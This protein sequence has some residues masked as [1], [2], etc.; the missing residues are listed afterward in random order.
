ML[1]KRQINIIPLF[2]LAGLLILT[3]CFEFVDDKDNFHPYDEE[4]YSPEYYP[5][6]TY[7]KAKT[8]TI[9]GLS[10]FEEKY[11]YVG[12][13]QN[14]EQVSLDFTFD[15]DDTTRPEVYGSSY[16]YEGVIEFELYHSYYENWNGG[17][18][19]YVGFRVDFYDYGT[20][21]TTR[22]YF[23][24]RSPI[25]FTSKDQKID[26]SEFKVYVFR[27]TAGSIAYLKSFDISASGITLD[28]LLLT[29]NC[30]NY[31]QMLAKEKLKELYK[32]EEKTL[33]FNGG[34][35]LYSDTVIYGEADII[36]Q[37]KKD[38]AYIT[39]IITLTDIPL[40]FPDNA[41]IG[42]YDSE[43]KITI[44]DSSG[45]GRKI[46]SD[47]I[48]WDSGNFSN[49]RW[50]IPINYYYLSSD[51]SFSDCNFY[52]T[53]YLGRKDFGG[54][55]YYTVPIQTNKTI[56]NKNAYVGDLGKVSLKSVVVSGHVYAV[57][58]N[59]L[60]SAISVEIKTPL[61]LTTVDAYFFTYPPSIPESWREPPFWSVRLPVFSSPTQLSFSV[62][63]M[64][65]ANSYELVYTRDISS[66]VVFVENENVSNVNFYVS[67]K[68]VVP[69]NAY[70]LIADTW[71]HTSIEDSAK[72]DWYSLDVIKGKDYYFWLND[73]YNGDGSKTATVNTVVFNSGGYNKSDGEK[74]LY[75]SKD[76]NDPLVYTAGSSGTVYIKVTAPSEDYTGTY[77]IVYS[78]NDS[79]PAGGNA[80]YTVSFNNNGG[81]GEASS[82]SELS[83][84]EITLPL[85][86]GFSRDGYVFGGW[87]TLANGAG[88]NYVPGAS[89]KIVGNVTL[90]AKW[91]PVYTVTFDKNSNDASGTVPSM[92]ATNDTNYIITL[93]DAYELSN[94]TYLF[95]SWNTK[96][97]GTGT[98]YNAGAN[99]TVSGNVT[100]YARWHT[101]GTEANPIQLTADTWMDGNTYT[102]TWYYFNV[103]SGKTYNVWW[104]DSKNNT[105]GDGTKTLDIRVSAYLNGSST[106]ISGFSDYDTAWNYPA[107]ITPGS[108]GTVKLRV[109][110][111]S[112][113][114]S[115]SFSIVYS[116]NNNKPAGNGNTYS[117][118][119]NSND[120]SGTVPAT[121]VAVYGSNITLPGA[122]GL[123][124]IRYSFGGWN[125]KADGTGTDYNAGASFPVTGYTT[126]YAKWDPIPLGREGNPIELTANT[127]K[128]D[129]ITSSATDGEIWY[130]FYNTSVTRYYL[131]LNDSSD[132]DSTK[133]LDVKVDLYNSTA[134]FATTGSLFSTFDLGWSTMPLITANS[135]V[136]KIRV[137]PKNSGA[138]GTFAIMYSTVNFRGTVLSAD[139]WNYENLSGLENWWKFTAT[140]ATQYIHFIPGTLSSAYVQIYNRDG[141]SNGGQITLSSA[142][143]SNDWTFTVGQEYYVKVMS[144]TQSLG[145]YQIALNASDRAPVVTLPASA[146]NIFVGTWA[147]GN[148][149]ASYGEQW[150]KFKAISSTYIHASFD[151]LTNM[152]IQLFDSS[153]NPVGNWD[154]LYSGA[155]STSRTLTAGQVYYIKITPN[156]FEPSYPDK[157]SYMIGINSSPTAPMPLIYLPAYFIT[158]CNITSS[159]AEQYFKFTATSSTQYIDIS[160]GTLKS[161]SVQVYDADRNSVENPK[162]LSESIRYSVTSLT[163]GQE[164]Y[165]KVTPVSGT[166]TFEIAL[167]YNASSICITTDD[168]RSLPINR[169]IS[170]VFYSATWKDWYKFTATASTH[171]IHIDFEVLYSLLSS[172]NVYVY[173][174]RGVLVTSKSDIGLLSGKYFSASSFNVGQDYYVIVR[175]SNFINDK[176]AYYIAVNTSS[177]SP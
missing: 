20:Q 173:D 33:P 27:T 124:K 95:D 54:A 40:N 142:K 51:F 135:N 41:P 159:S 2:L 177:S 4:I 139:T 89:Y 102:A 165:I 19:W 172:I 170:S 132:G 140:S 174:S 123:S 143:K 3:A 12:L 74:Y 158:N 162:T 100:L 13:F 176:R 113:Y 117:V 37:L 157:G 24:S 11:V 25:N 69:E 166:G 6:Q 70:K 96:A 120:G 82:K 16:V 127:W 7:T 145:T 93:P 84:T 52:L 156:K 85:S 68:F 49:L 38:G 10:S 144:P 87:N 121:M 50:S 5:P 128:N 101:A 60:A 36:S 152:Y 111:Y 107:T 112:S 80:R 171:Y 35:K 83:E 53:V 76:W 92:Q 163:V 23:I 22:Q 150:F 61:G 154:N 160:L 79:K 26:F 29:Y 48:I 164:Y 17:G 131:W 155:R 43:L 81:R 151:T 175:P 47:R 78:T 66:P 141:S 88:T 72:V 64:D 59:Q 153:G 77:A 34:D 99:Y 44:V 94:G 118:A 116:E 97:D 109:A 63:V 161:M 115:G 137:Y 134:S 56:S 119:F 46:D 114:L 105:S 42:Y 65:A 58:N 103:T 62:I 15:K 39:G 71:F 73:K 147:S 31:E 129:S 86:E 57:V 55:D 125:T 126:L 104:N 106:P 18:S 98:K 14:E 28:E 9:S 90:Y 146:T 149:T 110:P 138:T 136:V 122:G 30:M 45:N 168:K 91:I 130:Y 169:W 108:T 8:I 32:N 21:V 167:P 1:K 67:D 133:T 148:I 75:H